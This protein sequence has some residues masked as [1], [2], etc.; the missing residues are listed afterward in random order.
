VTELQACIDQLCIPHRGD[1]LAAEMA[2]AAERLQASDAG[3]KALLAMGVD[4]EWL[5][6]LLAHDLIGLAQVSLGKGG[7]YEP[8]GPDRRLLLAVEEASHLADIAALASHD[9]DEWALRRRAGTI[10]GDDLIDHARIMEEPLRLFSRPMDWLCAG[11]GQGPAGICVL[12]WTPLALSRLRGLGPKCV[13]RCEAGA[14]ERLAGML[15]YGGLP[16]LEAVRPPMRVA[17]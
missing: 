13:I 8:E 16:R 11:T 17:A 12:D 6:L 1:G 7:S 4:A 3:L 2:A 10:L 5:A 9:R 14:K 15:A